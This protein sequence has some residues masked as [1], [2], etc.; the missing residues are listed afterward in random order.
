[1]DGPLGTRQTPCDLLHLWKRYE[2]S[3]RGALPGPGAPGQ[4]DGGD[5]ALPKAR[6]APWGAAVSP[7]G[8]AGRGGGPAGQSMLEPLT[9]PGGWGS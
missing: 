4:G 6:G 8:C 7:W 2:A 5:G 3:V 1:M 9:R